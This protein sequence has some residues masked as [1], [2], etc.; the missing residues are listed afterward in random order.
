M[1]SPVHVKEGKQCSRCPKIFTRSSAT[2]SVPALNQDM[3][4]I[5]KYELVCHT[6]ANTHYSEGE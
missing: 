4:N 2:F 3:P 6:C 5:V 1:A